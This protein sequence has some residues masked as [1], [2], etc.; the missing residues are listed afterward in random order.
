MTGYVGRIEARTDALGLVRA[1]VRLTYVRATTGLPLKLLR[2]LWRD[3][4]GK[5]PSSGR[6]HSDPLSG[7]KT[8][9]QRQEAAA[10]A[11]LYFAGCENRKAHSI[12]A[13]QF[14]RTWQA[15]RETLPDTAMDSSLAWAVIRNICGRL[16]W[17]EKCAHC[18][19]GFIRNHEQPDWGCPFCSGH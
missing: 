12:E 15:F 18:G 16:T 11:N 8:R 9:K 10:F 17:R 3:V 6:A 7:L 13:R 2:E 1:G 5:S 19:A 4:H 14:L